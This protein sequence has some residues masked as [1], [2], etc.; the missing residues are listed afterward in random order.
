MSNQ[1]TPEEVVQYHQAMEEQVFARMMR[2][3]LE[4]EEDKK[5]L[6][7]IQNTIRTAQALNRPEEPKEQEPD[8]EDETP[9]I[10]TD[11]VSDPPDEDNDETQP[12]TAGFLLGE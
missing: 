5:L 3:H 6:I 9:E 11:D 10:D 7:A 8:P 12:A 2:R 1:E 4:D